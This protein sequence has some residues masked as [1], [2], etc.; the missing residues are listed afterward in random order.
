MKLKTLKPRLQSMAS[1]LPTL[2]STRSSTVERKRGYSGVKDRNRIRK[3]DCG[4]C[5]ECKRQG[6]VAAGHQVDHIIPLWAGGSDEDNN[7]ETLCIPCHDAKT[8]R[9][10]KQ[11]AQGF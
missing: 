5:Q 7:K 2:P 9:E 4:L 11:R 10:A 3:R 8:A 6:R 1:R